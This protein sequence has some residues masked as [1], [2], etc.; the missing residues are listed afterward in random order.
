[1]KTWKNILHSENGRKGIECEVNTLKE[2]RLVRHIGIVF[3]VLKAS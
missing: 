1:M 2:I 3:E